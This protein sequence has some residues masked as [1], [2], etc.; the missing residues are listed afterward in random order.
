[1]PA[2]I[3]LGLVVAIIGLVGTAVA[4]SD[5]GSATAGTVPV[6]LLP[7]STVLPGEGRSGAGGPVIQAPTTDVPGA[8]GPGTTM[9]DEGTSTSTTVVPPSS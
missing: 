4:G 5:D 7:I 3:A 2:L 8:A 9:P 6:Q 1:M